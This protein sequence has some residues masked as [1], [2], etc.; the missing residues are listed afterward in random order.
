MESWKIV[1]RMFGAVHD[2]RKCTLTTVKV[3]LTELKTAF[4]GV[5]LEISFARF[6]PSMARFNA[7]RVP[8]RPLGWW[9]LVAIEA[10]DSWEKA[11]R[12]TCCEGNVELWIHDGPCGYRWT[13]AASI[14]RCA[15]VA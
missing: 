8:S 2:Y 7:E 10:C 9:E 3:T 11:V 15:R 1:K 14:P 4:A 13:G 6:R 12:D 5:T